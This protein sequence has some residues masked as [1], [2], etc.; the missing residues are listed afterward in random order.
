MLS[1]GP[2]AK[3]EKAGGRWY[4]H[5]GGCEEWAFPMEAWPVKSGCEGGSVLGFTIQCCQHTSVVFAAC[6]NNT[7]VTAATTWGLGPGPFDL[8]QD[9]S[10]LT[11][12]QE[13]SPLSG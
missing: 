2:E 12:G 8:G 4:Q 1:S 7:S 3:T 13:C 10:V 9:L 5:Q 11:T 6:S